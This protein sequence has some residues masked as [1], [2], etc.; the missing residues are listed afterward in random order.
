MIYL[1]TYP[2]PV[3]GGVMD[4]H[5]ESMDLITLVVI[6]LV[7]V[8]TGFIIR[9]GFE[10]IDYIKYRFRNHDRRQRH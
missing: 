9:E 7:G 5:L 4:F 8:I 3:N 1:S 10:A 6:Y 2:P